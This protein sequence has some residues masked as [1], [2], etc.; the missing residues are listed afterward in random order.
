[1]AHRNYKNEHKTQIHKNIILIHECKLYY[2]D[3]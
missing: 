2:N 1:M 3:L